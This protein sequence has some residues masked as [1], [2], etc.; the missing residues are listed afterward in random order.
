[1]KQSTLG[2]YIRYLRTENNMTQ[3][4]LADQLHVTDKAVS[5]WERDLSY[6]DISLLP[7][8][9]DILGVTVSDLLRVMDDEESPS[10]LLR[11][12]QMSHDIRTPIHII[13]GCVDLVEEYDDNPQKKKRYLEGIRQSAKYLLDR[14]EQIQRL[15]Q[16]EEP[17]QEDVRKKTE[18]RDDDNNLKR[19]DFAGKR[20]LI[21]EDI[22]L[23]REIAKEI[24]R[25]TG[26]SVEL[27]ENGKSCLELLQSSPAGYY[28]LILMDVSM[29]VMDGIEATKRIRQLGGEKAK[30]PIIAMTA[31]TNLKDKREALEAGMDGFTE[32]PMDIQNLYRIIREY[33]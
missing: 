12:V 16:N 9:A 4:A 15:A 17:L 30:I 2:S 7:K 3:A 11:I 25:R 1:M 19:F 26:A 8:L 6:P 23:N 13:L 10:R 22:E 18:R 28:N 14:Y 5:K 29:P 33:I 21:V 27:A 20:V 31:N 32:K 24:T